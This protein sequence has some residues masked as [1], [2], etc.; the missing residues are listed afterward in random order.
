MTFLCWERHYMIFNFFLWLQQT[1][2]WRMTASNMSV[3]RDDSMTFFFNSSP[4]NAMKLKKR[5]FANFC[6]EMFY[7]YL[8]L[9]N[10]PIF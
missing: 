7:A 8:V 9:V 2:F 5:F 10:Q 6:S 4:A 3:F 1:I